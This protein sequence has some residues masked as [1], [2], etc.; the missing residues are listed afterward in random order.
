MLTAPAVSTADMS[1]TGPPGVIPVTVSVA[2]S[3]L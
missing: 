2:V 1:G 3:I